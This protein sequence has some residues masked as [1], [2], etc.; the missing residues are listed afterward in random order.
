MKTPT[1]NQPARPIEGLPS[2]LPSIAADPDARIVR[3]TWMLWGIGAPIGL[4]LLFLA[5]ESFFPLVTPLWALLLLWPLWRGGRA[6]WYAII[7]APHQDWNGGYFEFDGRHVRVLVDESHALWVCAADVFDALGIEGRG[8]VPARVRLDAGRD[9]LHQ[10][11]GERL[12]WFSERG[13][14]AW[15]ARRRGGRS[16]DFARWLESEVLGPQRR[17]RLT[18]GAEAPPLHN[19]GASTIGHDGV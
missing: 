13:L 16:S 2:L 1:E 7:E 17:R 5:P 11:P 12:L 18:I 14:L 19:P 4:A 6:L 9:G 3:G 10:L 15:L 8:R